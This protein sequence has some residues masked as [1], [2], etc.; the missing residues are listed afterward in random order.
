VQHHV[1]TKLAILTAHFVFGLSLLVLGYAAKNYFG[2]KA[3]V[4]GIEAVSPV[5]A[6]TT[7]RVISLQLP[8]S[9]R[10]D[11]ARRLVQS[12]ANQLQMLHEHWLAH[13]Q[14][15]VIYARNQFIAWALLSTLALALV[16]IL[17]FAGRAADRPRGST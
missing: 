13:M 1:A 6:D 9:D 4:P 12:Q 17:H 15:H 3:I 8:E 11:V 14:F 16:V 2:L 10:G 7:A 5:S